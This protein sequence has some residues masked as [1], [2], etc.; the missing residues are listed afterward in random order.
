MLAGNTPVLV[1]NTG[2]CDPG[3]IVTP[4]GTRKIQDA[5]MA[6]GTRLGGRSQFFDQET[7]DGLVEQA[8][9]VQPR[10]VGKNYV[11]EVNAG[12]PVGVER[13]TGLP[14]DFYTV[15]TN[16]NGHLITAYPG[17]FG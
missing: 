3:I 13:S 2:P 7:V 17:T 8:R 4:K 9:G 15:V 14:T 11:R 1:H 5:H 16:S 10:L 12:R 6:G